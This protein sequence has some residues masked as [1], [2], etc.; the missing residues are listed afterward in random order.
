[1][2]FWA[3]VKPMVVTAA[4]S[5]TVQPTPAAQP[6]VATPPRPQGTD[7][8]P[9]TPHKPSCGHHSQLPATDACPRR[10]GPSFA[11]VFSRHDTDGGG[12]VLSDKVAA[13]LSELGLPIASKP[14]E[15]ASLVQ[16]LD[17]DGMGIV[18]RDALETAVA[19]LLGVLQLSPRHHREVF[20]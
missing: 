7:A 8:V 2:D 14:A 20:L 18:M 12:F 11:T 1:M 10:A 16:R 19:P 5:A 9:Y 6:P 17:A 15:V 13:I 4:P 3:A